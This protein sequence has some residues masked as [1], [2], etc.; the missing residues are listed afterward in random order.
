MD[1]RALQTEILANE[2]CAQYVVTNDMPK[3]PDAYAKDAA[4]AAIL[5][6]GRTKRATR[7]ISERGIR[8]HL[9]VVDAASI[10]KVLRELSEAT[11]LPAGIVAALTASGISSENHWSYLDTLQCAWGWLKSDA[12]LDIGSEKTVA[13]LMLIG[14]GIPSVASACQQLANLGVVSDKISA[15][16]VSRAMRGPWE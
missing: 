2:A 7:M 9:D 5:S 1:Y 16:D 14:A 4:I 10:L 13:L 11:A 12:G 6:E 3:D 15:S 8:D